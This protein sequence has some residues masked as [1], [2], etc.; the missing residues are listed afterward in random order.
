MDLFQLHVQLS[1]QTYFICNKNKSLPFNSYHLGVCIYL[2]T[3]YKSAHQC[4]CVCER[5]RETE[6]ETERERE[7]EIQTDR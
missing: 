4:V 2:L 1:K 3:C 5:E 6:T 7:R